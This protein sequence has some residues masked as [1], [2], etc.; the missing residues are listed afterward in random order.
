MGWT[1]NKGWVKKKK[2][3]L[4]VKKVKTSQQHVYLYQLAGD[5]LDPASLR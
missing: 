1:L 4:E 3:Y 5:S 2:G